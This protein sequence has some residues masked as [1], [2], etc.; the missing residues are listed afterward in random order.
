MLLDRLTDTRS[1]ALIGMGK[2]VGKTTALNHIVQEATARHVKLGLTSIGRDGE[3]VD[4]ISSHPKPP[5]AV[6]P[7]TLVATAALPERARA[8][9]IVERTDVRTAVGPVVIARAQV[10][11]NWEVS[12]PALGSGLQHVK[13]RFQA[14]G[15]ELAIFD[16]AF[17]RRS[18]AT[19][20]LTDATLLVSGAALD[21]DIAVTIA[22]TV[23]RTNLF[24]LPAYPGLPP[25]AQ[26]LLS[27]RRIGLLHKDGSVTTL[28]FR[29]TLNAHQQLAAT[30]DSS[31]QALLIGTALTPQ[32]LDALEK[33]NVIVHDGTHALIDPLHYKRWKAH[34]YAGNP[35]RL[36][37]LVANPFSP[38]G[39]RYE[40][41]EFLDRLAEAVTPLPVVDV[42]LGEAR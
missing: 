11:T 12:G 32:L 27:S 30:L 15:V 26:E 7:G 4:A 14:L 9:D 17:D 25:E 28:P 39:W 13:Q 8:F 37:C 29:S 3:L 19:P 35:I 34:L 20:T 24:Q 42:V 5:I 21:P 16:G 31:V 40:A 18:S 22:D 10:A 38:Y 2:N 1:L 23:H 36:P 41:H 6:P 33:V